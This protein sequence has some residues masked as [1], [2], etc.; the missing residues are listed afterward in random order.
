MNGI[1]KILSAVKQQKLLCRL[2]FFEDSIFL[3]KFDENRKSQYEISA[4]D[5]EELFSGV[6]F[7]TGILPTNTIFYSR[8]NNIEKIIIL[9]AGG[10]RKIVLNGKE[11]IIPCPNHIFCGKGTEYKIFAIDIKKP[12][13]YQMPLPNINLDGSICH[14]ST[15]FT[16]CTP[17]SINQNYETFWTSGF[18]EDLKNGR[19]KTNKDLI[20]FLF[21]LSGKRKFP[22]DMLL[23]TNITLTDLAEENKQWH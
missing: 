9:R 17:K 20:K 21:S 1:N 14:G 22:Q 8:K 16:K 7:S 10:K 2:D 12:F 4:D 18:N 19:I 6:E 13:L 3:T 5:I 23:E 11:I 15:K